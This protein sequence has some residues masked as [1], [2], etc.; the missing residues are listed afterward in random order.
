MR[1]NP[2]YNQEKF[3]DD[4]FYKYSDSIRK[5]RRLTSKKQEYLKYF[6][7][8]NGGRTHCRFKDMESLIKPFDEAYGMKGNFT[9]DLVIFPPL[10]SIHLIH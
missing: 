1:N 5:N 9:K 3:K 10:N 7:E 6:K 2:K 8:K 4:F